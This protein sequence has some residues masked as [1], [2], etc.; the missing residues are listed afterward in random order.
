[1]GRISYDIII[2]AQNTLV[3]YWGENG[4]RVIE[5]CL[6][7]TPL[8]MNS[9]EYLEHCIA[10]GGDWGQMLLTGIKK[11]YPLVWNTIPWDMGVN[12][13]GCLCCVLQLCGVDLSE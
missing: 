7:A 1:M 13:W 2:N 11:L 10:C 6:R 8:N 5:E 12:A 3:E 4:K 9:K